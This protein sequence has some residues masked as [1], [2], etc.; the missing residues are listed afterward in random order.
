VGT[1]ADIVRIESG[2]LR[3]GHVVLALK[4]A[5]GVELSE[6]ANWSLASWIFYNLIFAAA[7]DAT[8]VPGDP[9]RKKTV[10]ML[11]LKSGRN[12]EIASG[13]RAFIERVEAAIEHAMR[14]ASAAPCR[15]DL[16]SK[17]IESEDTGAELTT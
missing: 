1:S 5:G 8:L 14:N 6:T 15:I 3:V 9:R 12:V 11:T 13:E 17:K 4:D 10:L 2:V 16:D 7:T